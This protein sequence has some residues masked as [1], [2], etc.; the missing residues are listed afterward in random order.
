MII[1]IVVD[2]L[3]IIGKDW[4]QETTTTG[5][6]K[7]DILLT[8]KTKECINLTLWGD[9]CNNFDFSTQLPVIIRKGVVTEYEGN[10]YLKCGQTTTCWVDPDIAF[11]V[12]LKEW[13]DTEFQKIP[14]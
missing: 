3:A 9:L 10:K 7:R 11:A 2:V 6:L 8:D 1:K 5:K 12:E 4:G 13:F 14:K